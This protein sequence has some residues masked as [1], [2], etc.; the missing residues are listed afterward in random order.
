MLDIETP[1]D[2]D[3]SFEPQI[4]K[5]RQTRVPT[6]DSKIIFLYSQGLGTREIVETLEEWYG[7]EV[8]PTLVSRVTDAVLADVIE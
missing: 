2:R 4:I 1:G 7:T 8:S 6:L 5:K 3:G